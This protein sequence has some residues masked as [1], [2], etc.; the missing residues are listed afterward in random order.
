MKNLITFLFLML[1][2]A[3]RAQVLTNIIYGNIGDYGLAVQ[4]NVT[5][6]ATKL[7]PNPSFVNN[8]QIRT[9]PVSAYTDTNGYYSYTNFQAGFYQCDVSGSDLPF[10][11]NVWTNMTGSVPIGSL[12]T[13]SAATFPDPGTNYYTISQLNALWAGFQASENTNVSWSTTTNGA[14]RPAAIVFIIPTNG[15]PFGEVITN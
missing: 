14:T 2:L 3:A 8:I 9:S 5:V 10:Y 13:N 4:P 11:F 1:A 12:I 7:Y 6:T 15:I